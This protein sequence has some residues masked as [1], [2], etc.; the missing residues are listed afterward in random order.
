MSKSLDDERSLIADAGAG[1]A[2]AKLF[3]KSVNPL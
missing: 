1:H 3:F 2:I